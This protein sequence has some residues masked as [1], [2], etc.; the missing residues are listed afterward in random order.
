DGHGGL[1]VGNAHLQVLGEDI[2]YRI[3]HDH[4]DLVG[5]V[6]HV[7][8]G[9]FLDIQH[10]HGSP[11]LPGIGGTVL[12]LEADRGDVPQVDGST[13]LG[14]DHKV[15]QVPGP[16]DLPDDPDGPALST[17]DQVPG[18]DGGSPIGTGRG[19]VA[20]AHL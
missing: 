1:I 7:L 19:D 3:V 13:L 15:L 8:S 10:D 17:G 12:F 18:R 4:A 2:L 14:F 9:A 16:F 6:H 11:E 20:K 5:G